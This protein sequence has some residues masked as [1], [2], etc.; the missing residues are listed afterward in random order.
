MNAK[1]MQI[2]RPQMTM[3]TKLGTLAMAVVAAMTLGGAEPA[4]AHGPNNPRV[5][6][7]DKRW[8][9]NMYH[10]PNQG[11]ERL[12]DRNMLL[13]SKVGSLII[14][15][16]EVGAEW[17]AG[18]RIWWRYWLYKWDA[19]TGWQPLQGFGPRGWREYGRDPSDNR[20]LMCIGA[21]TVPAP[22]CMPSSIGRARTTPTGRASPVIRTARRKTKF[23]NVLSADAEHAYNHYRNKRKG[24]RLSVPEREV[25]RIYRSQRTR[26]VRLV[27]MKDQRK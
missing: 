4:F 7:P 15:P 11:A 17:A 14:V 2:D 20:C 23:R 9:W 13:C 16:P 25:D 8:H 10:V 1:V 26:R 22:T 6:G 18:E 12:H 3:R 24:R 19:A 5:E 27:Y 21:L